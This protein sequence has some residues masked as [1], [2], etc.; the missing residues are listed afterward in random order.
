MDTLIL[1]CT[2]YPLLQNIIQD[3]FGENLTL[4]DPGVETAIQVKTVLTEKDI[5]NK[6]LENS[7]K[8]IF[9]TT[10]PADKFEKIAKHWLKR[11]DFEVNH[12]AV[13]E[14]QRYGK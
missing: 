13:E 5:F 14:L 8:H 7:N 6:G 3:Y 1:G 2:H 11:R 9:Y 12:I 10:G 4:I